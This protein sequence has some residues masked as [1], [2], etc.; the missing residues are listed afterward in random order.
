MTEETSVPK[1]SGTVTV[2]NGEYVPSVPIPKNWY[3]KVME[4][5]PRVIIIW[6]NEDNDYDEY[7]D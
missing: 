7:D 4:K 3:Q 6:P 1:S 2:W 5:L